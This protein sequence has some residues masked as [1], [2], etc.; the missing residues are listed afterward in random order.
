MQRRAL[1][2]VEVRV[3]RPLLFLAT[4][5]LLSAC[6]DDPQAPVADEPQGTLVTPAVISREGSIA[7]LFDTPLDTRGAQDPANFV[8]INQ[9]TGLR[10][11]GSLRLGRGAAGDNVHL[12]AV[13]PSAVPHAVVHSHSEFVV[14]VRHSDGAALRYD[15]DDGSAARLGYQL[16]IDSVTDE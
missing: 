12:H 7:V 16:G 1:L 13:E 9:C 14:R 11:A 3:C 15:G 6:D 10:V 8:V 2:P 4:L 5:A